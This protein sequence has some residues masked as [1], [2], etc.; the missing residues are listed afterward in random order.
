M[1]CR[2]YRVTRRPEYREDLNAIETWIAQDNPIAAVDIWLLIDQQVDHLADPNFP[3]RTSTRVSGALELIAHE[4]CIVY[5]DQNE[6]QCLVTVHAVVHVA[7]K[8][9]SIMNPPTAKANL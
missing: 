8:T 5:F 3:R 2:A 4:N 6:D 1:S 7:R 9:P